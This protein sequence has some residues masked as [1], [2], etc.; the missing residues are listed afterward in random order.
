MS[1][2]QT[3]T[4]LLR[5]KKDVC[6]VH[7]AQLRV[8]FYPLLSKVVFSS[9]NYTFLIGI[10]RVKTKEQKV[11]SEMYTMYYTPDYGMLTIAYTIRSS[12]PTNMQIKSKFSFNPAF[13]KPTERA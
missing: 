2:E 1:V 5:D 6:F 8:I 4:P 7:R 9:G 11:F 10:R 3:I 12:I 13:P